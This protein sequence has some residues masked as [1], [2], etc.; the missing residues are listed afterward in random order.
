MKPKERSPIAYEQWRRDKYQRAEDAAYCFG[1]YLIK[2]CRDEVLTNALKSAK[3][4]TRQ[5]VEEAVDEALHNVMDLIEEFYSTEAGPNHNITFRLKA[6]ISEKRG[7]EVVEEFEIA[8]GLD[9][10]VTGN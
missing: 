9:L 10:L 4:E 8:P 2:H 5:I 1:Y 7:G 6:E 3:P